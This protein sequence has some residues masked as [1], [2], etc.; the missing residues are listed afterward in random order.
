MQSANIPAP[1]QD[2][3]L[4]ELQET[5]ARVRA[6]QKIYATYSQEKVDE[7]FK[8]A[9]LAAN[10]A[11]IPLA[12]QAVE[13][14]GMGVVEDK[15]IK[16]HYA[17][18]FIYNAFKDVKTCGVIERD[19]AAGIEKIAE[20]VGVIGAVIPTTN[21]TSTAI[22]KTLIALKTRNGVVIS[23]LSTVGALCLAG[24]PEGVDRNRLYTQLLISACCFS[25]CCIIAAY[26]RIF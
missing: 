24:A 14:T 18:E 23:P 12:K 8:A 16:N 17:S 6:A 7:I 5:I 22:F 3:G 15:I 21:P 1:V 2:D 19:E 11:R 10:R 25:V 13:E 26:F 9:S 4:A 20:P